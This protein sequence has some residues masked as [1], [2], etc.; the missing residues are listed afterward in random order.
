M[1]S[2]P[3]LVVN[4]EAVMFRAHVLEL[5]PRRGRA[6]RALHDDLDIDR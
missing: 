2:P 3:V 5:E 1:M 6:R 4:S